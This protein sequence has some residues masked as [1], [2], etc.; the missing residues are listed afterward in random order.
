[1]ARDGRQHEFNDAQG[2]SFAVQEDEH[3]VLWFFE[4]DDGTRVDA[5]IG[6]R[7]LGPMTLEM[8]NLA[9]RV[10][11][12]LRGQAEINAAAGAAHDTTRAVIAT[13]A[14]RILDLEAALG[15]VLKALSDLGPRP[16]RKIVNAAA[17]ADLVLR[18]EEPADVLKHDDARQLN[19]LNGKELARM[20]RLLLV[21][22]SLYSLTIGLA[23]DWK[24]QCIRP[25][26]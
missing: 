7:S 11:E 3:G 17:A 20:V 13:Q 18:G 2:G 19:D 5:M 25:P 8:L 1:M 16:S 23:L 10:D 22:A 15:E 12:E 24:G 6:G 4:G 14:A 26:D 21:L 9:D